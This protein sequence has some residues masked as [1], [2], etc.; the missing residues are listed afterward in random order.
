MDG[1]KGADTTPYVLKFVAERTKGA[2]L[3]SNVALVKNNAVVGSRIAKA[4]AER[5]APRMA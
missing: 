5:E 3:K 2:S 4:L 1:V